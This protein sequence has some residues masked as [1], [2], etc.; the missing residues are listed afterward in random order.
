MSLHKRFTFFFLLLA[1][2]L[3]AAD[4]NQ[5]FLK[6]AFSEGITV[7]LR[8][9][10]YTDGVLVTDKGGV[11]TGPNLRIQALNIRYTRKKEEGNQVLTIEAEDQLMIEYGEYVLVGKRLE[12][13]LMTKTGFL[14]GGRSGLEPWFFGGDIIELKDDNSIVIHEGYIT[15]SPNVNPDWQIKTSYA[16]I[17]EDHFLS[18]KDVQF[19]FLKLPLFWVPTFR[20]NLDWIL[21]SP[22]RYRVR[23]GGTQGLRLGVIYDFIEWETFQASLRLDYRFNRGPGGGVETEYESLDHRESCQTINYIAR[24]SSTEEPHERTRYLFQGVYGYETV[25]KTF[26]VDM[27]YYW[28]SDKEMP[29][30]YYDNSLDI[31]TAGRTQLSVH[32]QI[33]EIAVTNLYARAR[34]NEFQTVKQEL[35]VISG[36]L[37]PL[38]L[39][40]TGIITENS[41]NLGYVDFQYAPDIDRAPDFHSSRLEC[42]HSSYRPFGIGPVTATPQIT[43]IGIFYGNSPQHDSKMLG[44]FSVGGELKTHLRR[45]YDGELLHAIE[46]YVSY[47]YITSP[48][49][50]PDDHFIFDIDDGWAYLNTLRFGARNLLYTPCPLMRNLT[51]DTFCYAFFDTPTIGYT[52]PKIYTQILWDMW[53]TLR[54]SVDAAWDMQHGIVDHFNIHTAWTLTEDLALSVEYRHRSAFA[55]RKDQPFNFI[56]ESFRSEE[57]LLI[58]PLSDRRNT[59]LWKL[60]Y[61]FMPTWAV[62]CQVRHGWRRVFE[63]GYLEYQCDLVSNLRTAWD[64]RLSYQKRED[65]HRVAFYVSL[66]PRR[67][68]CD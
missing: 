52:V 51:T 59:L 26:T 58:T 4:T 45:C 32:R 20:T 17:Y 3:Q 36:S 49:V 53:P 30:D 38:V 64:F 66:S 67:P 5:D 57:R 56:L 62:E 39:G 50:N 46:P 14:Y 11:I 6:E 22:L 65:D 29:T 44:V 23:W 42:R 12:Y 63:P 19:R 8:E 13:N 54:H 16:H 10:T 24:D 15:T 7:D 27:T 48:S 43:G 37:R 18:A 47:Q 34:I 60:F 35:P 25:G 55:W 33:D 31:K 21:D 2:A 1:S 9:P 40:D 61:R 41:L 68:R 28:V